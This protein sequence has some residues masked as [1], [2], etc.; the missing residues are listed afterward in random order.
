MIY[1][2]RFD[3]FRTSNKWIQLVW[4]DPNA[5]LPIVFGTSTTAVSATTNANYKNKLSEIFK[6]GILRNLSLFLV[7]K[8]NKDWD[9]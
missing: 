4:I 2:F 8:G 6:K 3:N 7:L 9:S 5:A 1:H